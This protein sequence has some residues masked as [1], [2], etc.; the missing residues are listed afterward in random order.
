[1]TNYQREI[2]AACELMTYHER[3]Q[4][5]AHYAL[6]NPRNAGAESYQDNP[7][8]VAIE[9]AESIKHI[10][11]KITANS[12]VDNAD[13][14][15]RYLVVGRCS[16][17]LRSRSTHRG[18]AII[19][20]RMGANVTTKE[21]WLAERASERAKQEHRLKSILRHLITAG[22][23]LSVAH[24][25]AGRPW[26][27]WDAR[28]ADETAEMDVYRDIRRRGVRWI[29]RNADRQLFADGTLAEMPTDAVKLALGESKWLLHSNLW[30]RNSSEVKV[31]NLLPYARA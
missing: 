31:G 7:L 9:I 19:A 3:T 16:I 17:I 11:A 15:E 25:V 20:G 8:A 30:G 4:C 28:T 29:E 23:Y 1:M 6:P 18:A 5:P 22:R 24:R 14:H 10:Q 21:A 2:N 27:I 12:R 13:K 26:C